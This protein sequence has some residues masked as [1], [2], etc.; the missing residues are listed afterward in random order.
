MNVD[1]FSDDIE[2]L[3]AALTK[4]A[5]QDTTDTN[6]ED[7]TK[8]DLAAPDQAYCEKASRL[9]KLSFTATR[10]LGGYL[11]Y[12]RWPDRERFLELDAAL[13]RRR[14]KGHTASNLPAQR[15]VTRRCVAR[16]ADGTRCVGK[17]E[18]TADYAGARCPEHRN[19]LYGS[20]LCVIGPRNGPTE[21][22]PWTPL[23]DAR[24]A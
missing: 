5:F 24:P 21:S 16:H 2:Y 1:E 14:L 20:R 19:L 10:S 17:F 3:M 22:T 8:H 6:Q 4:S 15:P 13:L 11:D 18:P 7:S 12:D 9:E 23:S